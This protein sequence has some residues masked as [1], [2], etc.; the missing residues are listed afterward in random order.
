MSLRNASLFEGQ[1]GTP[2][3]RAQW[4]QKGALQPFLAGALLL[5]ADRTA[6]RYLRELWPKAFPTRQ[7]LPYEPLGHEDGR[8]TDAFWTV[9]A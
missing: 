5:E 2:I 9:F 7:A 3:L 6:T 1:K 4:A 8:G